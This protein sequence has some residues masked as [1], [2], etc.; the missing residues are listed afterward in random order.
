MAA[1]PRIPPRSRSRC[2]CSGS[3]DSELTAVLSTLV[4]PMLGLRLRGDAPVQEP[5]AAQVAVAA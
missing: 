3:P 5:P 2:I 4:F 1:A